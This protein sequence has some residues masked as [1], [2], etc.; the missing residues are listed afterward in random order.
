MTAEQMHQHIR[1][2]AKA[3]NVRL[4]ETDVLSA[5]EALALPHLRLVLLA[6]V[7][8]ECGYAVALHELGHLA[9]P[10]GALPIRQTRAVRW[11]QEEAAWEWARHYALEWTP[12][13]NQVAEWAQST[14]D[15]PASQ[16]PAPAV[17]KPKQPEGIDWKKWEQKQQR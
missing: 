6:P 1:A 8:E 7:R 4:V 12:A 14:Y 2:L 15:K 3:F 5:E 17:P 9:H 13:M 16:P 10:S 11:D